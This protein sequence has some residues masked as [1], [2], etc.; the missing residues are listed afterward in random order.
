MTDPNVVR[1]L[2][3]LSLNTSPAI[4]QSIYDGWVLRAS[5]T[6]TRRANSITALAASTLPMADKIAHCEAWYRTYGQPPIFRFTE[7]FMPSGLE[8]MLAS[9]GYVREG[10]TYVMRTPLR[11]R[12]FGSIGAPP[13]TKV[14]E[15]TEAEGLADM[16]RMKGAKPELQERDTRRQA[17]WQ[18]EQQYLSLKTINGVMCTGLARM[19]AGHLGIFNMRTV[20]KVR[21]KGFATVLLAHLLEWG[22]SRGAQAAFLQVDQANAP[23]IAVYRKFGFAPIY[24]YW[25]RV[26]SAS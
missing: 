19:E 13:G 18:G 5:G 10:D 14:V 6:D 25:Y 16:H 12:T 20:D 22:R 21:G 3:E 17:L 11:D 15:R 24:S 1:Q 4:H 7:A 2:E 26:Q 23:A 9:R 8:A